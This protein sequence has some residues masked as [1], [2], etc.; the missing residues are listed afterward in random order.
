MDRQF[1]TNLHH[2][3]EVAGLS[4][5]E[6]ERR[7]G[8]KKSYVSKLES[9][10]VGPPSKDVCGRIAR[11]VGVDEEVVWCTAVRERLQ[12]L[13]SDILSYFESSRDGELGK[14]V[15]SLTCCGQPVQEE[16]NCFLCKTCGRFLTSTIPFHQHLLDTI[17]DQGWLVAV[18]NDYHLFGKFSTFWMFTKNGRCV[19]GEGKSDTEALMVVL[20]E[21]NKVGTTFT[22]REVTKACENIGYDLECGACAEIFFTNETHAKHTCGQENPD[23]VVE[24]RT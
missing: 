16:H 22:L 5:A 20:K 18:H 24:G 19:I 13:D 7:I 15:G 8:K 1:G 10:D 3:R 14:L 11:A 17:R 2:W 4:R 9:G 6:L 12:R 23:L 21:I